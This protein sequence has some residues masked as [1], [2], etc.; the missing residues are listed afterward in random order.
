VV[1]KG[2]YMEE[3]SRA[4]RIDPFRWKPTA[5]LVERLAHAI[6]TKKRHN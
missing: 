6:C 2:A 1:A 4:E 3:L 5:E